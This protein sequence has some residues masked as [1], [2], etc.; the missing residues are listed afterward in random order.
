MEFSEVSLS[1]FVITTISGLF[2][3]VPRS[4]SYTNSPLVTWTSFLSGASLVNI[5]PLGHEDIEMFLGIFGVITDMYLLFHTC[6]FN[7]N[8]RLW[9]CKKVIYNIYRCHLKWFS[10]SSL[11]KNAIKIFL[12]KS[13][14]ITLDI[15]FTNNRECVLLCIVCSMKKILDEFDTI[16]MC[17]MFGSP[18]FYKYGI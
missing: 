12:H 17:I 7:K 16:H 2:D 11:Y 14:S 15:S 4:S 5:V 18:N 3:V 9:T 1:R 8:E 10:S 6:F 13:N